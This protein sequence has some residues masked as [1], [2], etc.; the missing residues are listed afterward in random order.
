MD[1][2]RPDSIPPIAEWL[3]PEIAARPRSV[4]WRRTRSARMATPRAVAMPPSPRSRERRPAGRPCHPADVHLLRTTIA[5]SP[6]S[7]PDRARPGDKPAR[8]CA[9]NDPN[10]RST[11]AYR[12]HSGSRN[13]RRDEERRVDGGRRRVGAG[14]CSHHLEIGRYRA[15]G[16]ELRVATARGR[17]RR[18]P[19]PR[20]G[21]CATYWAA[22]AG[23]ERGGT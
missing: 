6:I 19:L 23:T 20:H 7:G 17:E 16:R 3:T 10:R 8:A 15:R 12:V 1:A 5:S 4:R 11:A 9:A 22:A 14:S 13:G 18:A 21:L 2:T